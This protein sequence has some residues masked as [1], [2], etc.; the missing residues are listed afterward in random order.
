MK[1]PFKKLTVAC[2]LAS[3]IAPDL[4][5]AAIVVRSSNMSESDFQALAMARGDSP[6]SEFLTN[7][8]QRRLPSEMLD[9]YRKRLVDAQAEWIAR[10]QAETNLTPAI[11]SFLALAYETDWAQSERQAFRLFFLRRFEMSNGD[12]AARQALI[13][14]SGPEKLSLEEVSNTLSKERQVDL[15]ANEAE[16]MKNWK[17]ASSL[18]VS[19]PSDI[20][21]VLLNGRVYERAAFS[22]AKFPSQTQRF[23]LVSNLYQPVSFILKGD[24]TAWPELNRRPWSHDGCTPNPARA[25]DLDMT[26]NVL[27]EGE[28]QTPAAIAE[29]TA[30]ALAASTHTS[31]AEMLTKFGLDRSPKESWPTAPQE[32][33]KPF[34]RKSWFWWSVAGVVAA[35]AAV[36]FHQSRNSSSDS[37]HPVNREDW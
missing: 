26:V 36:A 23:T 25:T 12:A 24:E 34:Y 11:D 1:N 35:G 13:A 33:E 19:L 14:Y 5:K 32:A 30:A 2:I 20:T 17:S 31:N 10:S 7:E 18:G 16:D 21:H 15:V 9:L 27:N 6:M 8:N 4:S 37:V 22:E 28:C 3:L 29:K